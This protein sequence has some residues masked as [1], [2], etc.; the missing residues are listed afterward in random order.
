MSEKL[1]VVLIGLIFSSHLLVRVQS[2]RFEEFMQYVQQRVFD[3]NLSGLP[4]N[5]WHRPESSNHASRPY[6]PSYSPESPIP[7]S[8][9]SPSPFV[10]N[11][12]EYDDDD[13]VSTVQFNYDEHVVS[14]SDDD[15][16]IIE[17][18]NDENAQ[19]DG[20]NDF[21]LLVDENGDEVVTNSNSLEKLSEC[22]ICKSSWLGNYPI[23]APCGHVS[24]N[25][26]LRQWMEYKKKCPICKRGIASI[27]NCLP[28]Y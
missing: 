13:D 19:I 15:V 2:Q 8:P 17:P 24:C 7:D 20:T 4:V 21:D 3:A 5:S 22:S 14:D 10:P 1:S 11:R 28:I 18:S 25:V 27:Q 12:E 26:C 16:Q 6:S 23:R 9:R